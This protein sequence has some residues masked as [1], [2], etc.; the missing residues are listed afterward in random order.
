MNINDTIQ[1]KSDQWNADDFVAGPQ[2]FTIA[3]VRRADSAE[4]PVD[5]FFVGHERA[6]RP[7][8]SMR[9]VLVSAWGVEASNYIGRRVTLFCD[10]TVKWGGQE[11]GG[12]RVSH[13]SDLDKPLTIALTVTRGKRATH[14]VMPL[15]ALTPL[16][17]LR[18]E[19]H[20][21]TPDR[22]KAIEAEVNALQGKTAPKPAP[23]PAADA[24]DFDPTLDASWG[25]QQ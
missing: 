7:N 16:E 4:Q 12:I 5:V 6:W 1:P 8:K 10:P 23:E 13:L 25:E 22:K 9:R 2:T 11:T 3:E 14:K 19:W 17:Q 15:P 18:A 24:D 20:T 21:A